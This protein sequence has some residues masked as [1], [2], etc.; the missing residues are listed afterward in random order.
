MKVE[1]QQSINKNMYK[2]I[3][4]VLDRRYQD[5]TLLIMCTLLDPRFKIRY[6]K[7]DDESVL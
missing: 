7:Y 2:T 6:I 5:N 1:K 3:I 4:E